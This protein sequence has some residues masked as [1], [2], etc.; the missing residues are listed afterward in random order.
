MKKVLSLLVAFVFMQVQSQ[1]YA[2]FFSGSAAA[3]TGTYAGVM[4]PSIAGNSLGIFVL[5]VPKAGLASGAFAMFAAS[6]AFYGT[7]VG[8]VDPDKLTLT[9]LA[10]AQENGQQVANNLGIIT[11]FTV[12]VA[13]AAG[14]ITA[15]LKQEGSNGSQSGYRIVGSGALNTQSFNTNFFGIGQL[16]PGPTILVTVDGFQQ[17]ATVTGTIDINALTGALNTTTASGT[18]S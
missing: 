11:T 10:Q 1:A 6:G 2:P 12:P 4:L 8:L 16:V 18:G 3:V 7:I 17:S 5:G 13:L 9:A 14:S 15:K